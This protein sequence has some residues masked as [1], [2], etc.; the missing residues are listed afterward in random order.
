VDCGELHFP[1]KLPSDDS[2]AAQGVPSAVKATAQGKKGAE[3]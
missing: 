2:P 3:S 1:I